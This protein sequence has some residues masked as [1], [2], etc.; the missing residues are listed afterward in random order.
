MKQIITLSVIAACSLLSSC[1]HE[2]PALPINAIYLVDFSASRGTSVIRWYKEMIQHSISENMGSK[3]MATVLPID[4]NSETS[5]QEI[6]KVDF[7][8]NDYSNEFAGLQ[9][10]EIEQ[11]NHRDSVST[12]VKRFCA[13]F[14]IARQQRAQLMGGTDI[15]GAL[16]LC[17]K[18]TVPGHRNVVIL[19]SDMLQYTDIKKLNFENN[20]NASQE[21]EHYMSVIEKIDLKGVEIIVLCGAQN[22]MRPEKFNAVKSFW[23]RY[24]TQCHAKVLDYSSGAVTKLDEVFKNKSAEK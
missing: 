7:S 21:I 5:S 18:Y 2:N 14:D 16:R 10:D 8:K 3:D 15:F 4:F 20:L 22:N 6:F 1:K 17:G 9:K 23:E 19:L 12:A 24:F 11:Q 13:S